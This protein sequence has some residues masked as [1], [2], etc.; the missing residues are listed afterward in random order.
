VHHFGVIVTALDVIYGDGE[1]FA[2]RVRGGNCGQQ[3]GRKGGNAAFARQVIAY[4]GDF[5]NFR[6]LLQ[7]SF[8]SC[9]PLA[10]Y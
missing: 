10:E 4:E 1:A 7:V 5:T 6:V 2:L 9:E 3:V 8:L